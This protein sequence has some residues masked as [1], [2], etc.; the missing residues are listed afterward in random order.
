MQAKAEDVTFNRILFPTDFSQLS[1]RVGAYALSLAEK[2]GAKLY[3][4]HVMDNSIEYAAFY[5]PHISFEVLDKE[6]ESEEAKSLKKKCD[7]LSRK[8]KS[9]EIEPVIC[10][11]TP[12]EEILRVARE[13]EVDLIVIG[14]TGTGIVGRIVFGSNTESVIRHSHVPVL[15]IP[16][17]DA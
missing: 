14:T 12:H 15:S 6:E 1:E 11:G 8:A 4:L 10:I 17:V 2:F 13:K 9:V 3:M 5:V 16:L 7:C